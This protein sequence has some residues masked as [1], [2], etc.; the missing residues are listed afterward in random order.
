MKTF[1]S[2]ANRMETEGKGRYDLLSPYAIH[3]LALVYEEGCKKYDDRNWE[4]GIPEDNLLDHAL[5][6]IFAHMMGDRSED[7]IG[8]ATWNLCAIMHFQDKENK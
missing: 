2:G 1:D 6:H 3:R 8:H 4:K 5:R 7:H